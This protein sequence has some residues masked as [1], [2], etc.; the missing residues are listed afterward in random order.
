[1]LTGS[2]HGAAGGTC[3]EMG[4]RK[5]KKKKADFEVSSALGMVQTVVGGVGVYFPSIMHHPF[6]VGRDNTSSWAS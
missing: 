3:E 6:A 4:Q 5:K 1:M 2:T